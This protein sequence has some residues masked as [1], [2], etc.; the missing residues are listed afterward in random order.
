M[1]TVDGDLFDSLPAAIQFVA[2]RG[3]GIVYTA[4]A[5]SLYAK[6]LKLPEGVEIKGGRALQ[7]GWG[8]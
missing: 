7:E 5:Y 8:G 4:M 6:S 1:T 3:G 2:E